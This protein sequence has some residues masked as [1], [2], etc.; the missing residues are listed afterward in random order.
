MLSLLASMSIGLELDIQPVLSATPPRPIMILPLEGS[1]MLDEITDMLS[2]LNRVHSSMM[3]PLRV[4]PSNPCQE[5]MRRL[6]CTDSACLKRSAEELSPTCAAFLLGSPEP[7]PL[8][9]PR[10]SAS[11]MGGPDGPS[12]FFS[13]TERDSSGAIHRFSGPISAMPMV[14]AMPMGVPSGLL[15]ALPPEFAALLRGNGMVGVGP[16][17]ENQE[18]EDDDRPAMHPCA[19]EI[20]A[21]QR[22]TGG[23][24]RETLQRCLVAHFA[25]LSPECRCFVH[26][27]VGD[28]PRPA[29]PASTP[30]STMTIMA[31][32]RPA[33][34]DGAR[35]IP[36][37]MAHGPMAGHGPEA[38]PLH[39]LS[40]FLLFAT[41]LL[42]TFMLAR[43]CV[44]GCTKRSPPREKRVVMLP[45]SAMPMKPLV[46]TDVR[47][48]QVAEPLK[49]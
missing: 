25:Q 32:P 18:E 26:H 9:A 8:P 6:R 21:C 44:L 29:S 12:G 30:P 7:S 41:I 35:M 46:V 14:R 20:G 16:D 3:Q 19:Q 4:V 24:G 10:L 13:I 27:L 31:G 48:V 38:H 1:G 2:Q 47:P 15:A 49:A 22:E 43:A 33:T 11:S 45:G 40:C 42:I 34:T 17:D 5:D 36:P 28:A 23:S 39:R 37:P